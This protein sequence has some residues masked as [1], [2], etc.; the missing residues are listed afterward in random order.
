MAQMISDFFYLTAIRVAMYL[1][2]ILDILFLCL[3]L[4]TDRLTLLQIQ[5]FHNLFT[6]SSWHAKDD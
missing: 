5:F 1:L 2:R 3:I 6:I 4:L